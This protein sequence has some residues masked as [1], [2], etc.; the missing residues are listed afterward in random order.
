MSG[1]STGKYGENDPRRTLPC[2]ATSINDSN[3][4]MKCTAPDDSPLSVI[5]AP[6][7]RN[8][9]KYPPVPPP[10]FDI[11]PKIGRASCRERVYMQVVDTI[12]QKK[13]RTSK[14]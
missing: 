6:L 14:M 13:L 1:C 2:D 4:S 12:V 10:S 11:I 8:L 9:P 5:L 3:N 7:G